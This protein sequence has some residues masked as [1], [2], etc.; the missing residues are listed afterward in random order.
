MTEDRKL[1]VVFVGAFAIVALI[2]AVLLAGIVVVLERPLTA[3]LALLVGGFSTA[4]AGSIALLAP[5]PLSKSSTAS[6]DPVAVNVVN[7]PAHP[8]PVDPAAD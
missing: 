6:D 5:S 3:E 2:G 7:P 4:A 1:V 8:V